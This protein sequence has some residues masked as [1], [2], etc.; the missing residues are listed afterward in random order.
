MFVF[1]RSLPKK[2][3]FSPCHLIL[4]A[5]IRMRAKKK[6]RAINIAL[7]LFLTLIFC[8]E[9]GNRT[10]TLSYTRLSRARLPIPPLRH[11]VLKGE[12]NFRHFL[13]LKL[14]FEEMTQS[15]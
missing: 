10:L 2:S 15:A 7:A 11:F 9:E 1:G 4:R 5:R 8:T 14:K 3:R 13:I 12:C 6:I